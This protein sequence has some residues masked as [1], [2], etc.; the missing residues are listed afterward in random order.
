[1]SS[2][3]EMLYLLVVLGLI[4]CIDQFSK[5]FLKRLVD[6]FHGFRLFLISRNHLR[7][8]QHPELPVSFCIRNVEIRWLSLWKSCSKVGMLLETCSGKH[9][10]NAEELL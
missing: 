9:A 4:G 2:L 10:P 1:M 8:A 5:P 6:P 7:D 3:Q